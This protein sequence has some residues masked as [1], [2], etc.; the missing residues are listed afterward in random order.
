MTFNAGDIVLITY[1]GHPVRCDRITRVT[2][3]RAFLPDGTQFDRE[4]GQGFGN[5]HVI[6]SC[7]D[8]IGSIWKESFLDQE[9]RVSQARQ[10][11][12]AVRNALN[13]I[14]SSGSNQDL[15]TA[16]RNLPGSEDI[17]TRPPISTFL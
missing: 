15:F 9:K 16:S 11:I 5:S 10:H 12:T 6:T 8:H 17:L 2:P 4:T 13:K 7:D 1:Q 14:L 3:K